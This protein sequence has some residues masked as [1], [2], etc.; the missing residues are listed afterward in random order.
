MTALRQV[1][2]PLPGA[3]STNQ[4]ARWRNLAKR[5][6]LEYVWFQSIYI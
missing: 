4:Y 5:I 6:D 3:W 2:I 1:T